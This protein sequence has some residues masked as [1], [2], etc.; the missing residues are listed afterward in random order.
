MPDPYALFNLATIGESQGVGTGPAGFGGAGCPAAAGFAP[1]GVAAAGGLAAAGAAGFGG[2]AGVAASEGGEGLV[3][4]VFVSDWTDPEGVAFTPPGTPGCSAVG[5][6]LS[7]GGG[8]EGDFVS[9][10]IVAKANLAI[11][12]VREER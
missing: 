2:V 1:A 5:F 3:G 12:R 9:S 8:V 7:S 6:G 4:V 10:G 11:H